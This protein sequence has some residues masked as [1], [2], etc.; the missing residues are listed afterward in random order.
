[1]KTLKKNAFAI[2]LSVA[3][4]TGAMFT[5]ASVEAAPRSYY[6][7]V[8]RYEGNL[9]IQ[10]YVA[11][12]VRPYAE[13]TLA[14]YEELLAK[15]QDFS[16]QSFYKELE[17]GRDFYQNEI[18]QFDAIL[19]PDSVAITVVRTEVSTETSSETVR[20]E[21]FEVSRKTITVEKVLDD[22][23]FVYDEITVNLGVEVTTTTSLT[24]VTTEF[25]SD[26]TSRSNT[27]TEVTDVTTELETTEST[28][29]LLVDSYPVTPTSPNQTDG[30]GTRTVDVLTAQEYKSLADV[31]LSKTDFL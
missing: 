19:N 1:M 4:G 16:D 3:V 18:A 15:Y 5:S 29:R 26:G 13:K 6:A 11:E 30:D 17:A 31:N 21:P 10:R 24:T 20:S 7:Y 22:T 14:R 2:A 9:E 23:V 8:E 27:T 25:L 12:I 28:E